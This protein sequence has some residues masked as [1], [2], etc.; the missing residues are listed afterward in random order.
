MSIRLGI[1]ERNTG[2]EPVVTPDLHNVGNQPRLLIQVF[3]RRFASVIRVVLK[4]HERKIL[5]TI[6]AFEIVKKSAKPRRAAS[7]ISPCFYVFCDSL[8]KRSSQPEAGVY[9]VNRAGKLQ[10]QSGVILGKHVLPVRFLAH[11]YGGDGITALFD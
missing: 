4:R 10:I 5:Q 3:P 6:V 7:R 11:F 9:S 2:R 8:K 1:E